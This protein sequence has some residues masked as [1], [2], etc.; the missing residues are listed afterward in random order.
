[1]RLI[2][3]YSFQRGNEVR[4]FFKTSNLYCQTLGLVIVT[5]T[6]GGVSKGWSE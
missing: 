6:T 4:S 3:C 5:V 2:Q 1:M